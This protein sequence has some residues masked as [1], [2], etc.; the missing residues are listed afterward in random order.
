MDSELI[1][2]EARIEVPHTC[3]ACVGAQ[4]AAATRRTFASRTLKTPPASRAQLGAGLPDPRILGCTIFHLLEGRAEI[5]LLHLSPAP[6]PFPD[7]QDGTFA[8]LMA[9]QFLPSPRYTP[10][11]PAAAHFRLPT[12]TTQ[13]LAPV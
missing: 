12:T 11:L 10:R 5:V 1:K 8:S 9:T 7:H 2:R 6:V 13:W 3:G 4:T